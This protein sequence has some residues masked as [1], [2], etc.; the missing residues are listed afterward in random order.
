VRQPCWR[1]RSIAEARKLEGQRILEARNIEEQRTLD[2]ALQAY[3]DQMTQ[4]LLHER[5]RTSIPDDEV[6]SVARARTLTALRVAELGLPD[7]PENA[8]LLRWWRDEL[9][10]LRGFITGSYRT[11]PWQ[12]IHSDFGPG[13]TLFD[14]GQLRAVLDFEFATP[15]ARAMDVAAGLVFTLRVWEGQ[16]DWQAAWAF[17]DGYQQ[18]LPLDASESAGLPWLIDYAIR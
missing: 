6:R 12:V 3:L 15:D 17:L 11:L 16:P 1:I 18:I 13:N 7:T 2:A 10:T 14:G 5:L 4:L 9:A 8:T